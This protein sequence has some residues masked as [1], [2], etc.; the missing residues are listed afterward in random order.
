MNR[1]AAVIVALALGVAA[2]AAAA[3]PSPTSYRAQLNRVCRG[4]TPKLKRDSEKM[5]EAASAGDANAFGAAL[6]HAVRLIL[7]QDA[8]IEKASV[9]VAMRA[10][11]KPIVQLLKTAD[12]HL[13]RAMSLGIQRDVRGM[14][15]EF[16]K[17][18]KLSAPLNRR[19][20][21]AGLRDCGSNQS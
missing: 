15:A 12:G 21:R 1:Y 5:K 3:A 16:N 11:M 4:Y 13:R 8:Y 9:P 7:A 17:V 14:L 2:P 19:L 6:V 10:Q 20:D 18:G